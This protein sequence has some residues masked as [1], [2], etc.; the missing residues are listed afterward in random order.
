MEINIRQA[1]IT[2]ELPRVIDNEQI[3]VYVPY[4]SNGSP[5]IAG[6]NLAHFEI[7]SNAVVSIKSN[8]VEKIEYN[9]NKIG[10]GDLEIGDTLIESVNLIHLELLEK[11]E[12]L[13][14]SDDAL[15][16]QINDNKNSI[17]DIN[18][19]IGDKS[20]LTGHPTLIRAVNYHSERISSHAIKIDDQR[21]ALEETNQELGNTNIKVNENAAGILRN[22]SNI[23]TNRNNLN[24][25]NSRIN[26]IYNEIRDEVKP[27]LSNAEALIGTREEMPSFPSDP[28]FPSMPQNSS[29]AKWVRALYEKASNVDVT[30][31]AHT[32]NLI[33]IFSQLQ[34]IDRTY[35]LPNF[36]ALLEFIDGTRYISAW[37]D[38]DG[39][40][41]PEEYKV[42]VS[43]LKTNDNILLREEG[44][45]D[46]WFEKLSGEWVA[47]TDYTY[48]YN[49]HV[50][51]LV[52]YDTDDDTI[53]E[54]DTPIGIFH[55]LEIDLTLVDERVQSA[56]EYA[57]NA[58]QSALTAK[59][60]AEVAAA[61]ALAAE[62]EFVKASEQREEVEN[63]VNSIFYIQRAPTLATLNDAVMLP[64]PTLAQ[65]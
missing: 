39:D 58:Q 55:R 34:G 63:L 14:E 24:V 32:N 61:E 12:D 35:V 51:S 45:S 47:P 46:F 49:G 4:A 15:Q 65:I 27:R 53:D 25:H 26:T 3:N 40:G 54:S 11:Y 28:S 23:A 1:V 8:I 64:T 41:Y 17:T 62:E 6:Y 36:N 2:P 50:Y 19:I 9:Y 30:V 31:L 20:N 7:D 60:F 16:E 56:L 37:E 44:V 18:N 43:D 57:N 10:Q 38:R 13:S 5:G 59:G 29:I 21:I 33:N 48:K 22:E 42:Y 52:A